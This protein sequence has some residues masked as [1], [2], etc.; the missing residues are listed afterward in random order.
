MQ[1]LASVLSLIV[2]SIVLVTPASAAVG[3]NPAI[4]VAID[5][6]TNIQELC[7]SFQTLIR[8]KG[9]P[10]AP[11]FAFTSIA[12]S[13]DS[14]NLLDNCTPRPLTFVD[15][16]DEHT[17]FPA[18]VNVKPGVS[19]EY[20]QTQRFLSSRMWDEAVLDP[21]DVIMRITDSTCLTF[22]D[23]HLPGFP[24][25]SNADHQFAFKSY[26]VPNELQPTEH[27]A[28]IFAY[29]IEFLI[30]RG[31]PEPLTDLWEGLKIEHEYE[32]KLSK[33]SDDFQIVRK[34]F[35][36]DVGVRDYLNHLTEGSPSADDFFQMKWS[37]G[38]LMKMAVA[39]FLDDF[40]VSDSHVPGVVEKDFLNHNLFERICRDTAQ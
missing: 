21:Y 32:H 6:F 1:I 28:G 16:I 12:L 35:M 34:D 13:V 29:T 23:E 31:K 38:T 30:L 15:V 40:V 19:Y 5:G 18:A 37:A 9:F 3:E 11:I 22:D 33:F 10:N 26:T 20:A 2:S 14:T 17:D 4:V 7:Y 36:R 25:S 8:A 27:V 39:L 24:Y